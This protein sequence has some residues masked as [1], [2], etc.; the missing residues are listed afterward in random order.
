MYDR[1]TI[2][3]EVDFRRERLMKGKPAKRRRSSD[4]TRIPFI[5]GGEQITDRTPGRAR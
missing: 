2:Q 5:G 1:M 3:S 4:R